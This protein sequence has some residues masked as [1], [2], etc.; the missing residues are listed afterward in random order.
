MR[1][2]ALRAKPVCEEPG[3]AQECVGSPLSPARCLFTWD[4]TPSKKPHAWGE[5]KEASSFSAFNVLLPFIKRLRTRLG[6]PAGPGLALGVWP[7]TGS[8]FLLRGSP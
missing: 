3:R 8:S 4:L 6:F 5:N 7:P 1:R 2:K